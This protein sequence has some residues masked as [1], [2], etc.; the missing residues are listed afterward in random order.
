M[1]TNKFKNF[2]KK[3]H[4][5]LSNIL[6]PDNIKCIFCG[7]DVPDFENKPY[8]DNCEKLIEFNNGN[9]CK[10]CDEPINNEAVVCDACQKNKRAFKKAFCPF[11]YSGVVRNAILSYKSSNHRYKSKVFAKYIA[12]RIIESHV[13]IDYI[14]YIPL[15][16]KKE[17]QRT[18][19]QSKLLASEISKLLNVELITI[20]EK[21]KD[22]PPQKFATYNERQENMIGT[23][24]L[25]PI[26]LD[27]NKNYLIVDDII[28]TCATVNYCAS[29]IKKKVNNVYVASIARNKKIK[30]NTN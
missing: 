30:K 2:I 14:T 12:N 21:S 24:S 27:K 9:R 6:F 10:I 4:E 11:V 3:T 15:T 8:C 13:Q 19:N 1:K 17:K 16:K 26:K 25:L 22:T 29:L 20:F 23:Y 7:S 18:F 5:F 28:T